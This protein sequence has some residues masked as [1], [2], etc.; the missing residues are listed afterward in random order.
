MENN[1]TNSEEPSDD[2]LY[3][4]SMESLDTEVPSLIV[5][6]NSYKSQTI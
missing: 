6:N 4:V 3:D 1:L 5:V 2:V